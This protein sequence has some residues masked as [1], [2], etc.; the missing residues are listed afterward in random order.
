MSQARELFHETRSALT[1]L[2]GQVLTVENAIST[3][4]CDLLE[5]PTLVQAQRGL[6][7]LAIAS[8]TPPSSPLGIKDIED[9]EQLSAAQVLVR[10]RIHQASL[11]GGHLLEGTGVSFDRWCAIVSALDAGLDPG[12][13]PQ[14]SEALVNRGFLQRA[15]KLGART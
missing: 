9:S 6:E 1:S 5:Y 13:E 10:S 7:A 11:D 8:G 12:I 4:R 15:Y 14:E 3:H 2:L